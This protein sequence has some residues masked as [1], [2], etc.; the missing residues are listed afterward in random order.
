MAKGTNVRSLPSTMDWKDLQGLRVTFFSCRY[1]YN[2][3]VSAVSADG[4]WIEI[5]ECNVVYETGGFADNQ[6]SDAQS[7]WPAKSAVDAKWRLNTEAIES[8]GILDK[9]VK[10][11]AKK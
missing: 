2:G 11:T 6:F 5:S 9:E 4:T 7:L 10:E 1:F 8:Y 3:I